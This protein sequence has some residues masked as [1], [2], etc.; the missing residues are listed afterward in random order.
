QRALRPSAHRRPR[1]RGRFRRGQPLP[2]PRRG[3][4]PPGRD[5]LGSP[6]R[7][8]RRGRVRA[9]GRRRVRHAPARRRRRVDRVG[10]GPAAA[11][12]DAGGG[13]EG[14]S[15][16][17]QP[18]GGDVPAA[19][20][21][22]RRDAACR[23][24]HAARRQGQWPQRG[25]PRSHRPGGEYGSPPM[26]LPLSLLLALSLAAARAGAEEPGRPFLFTTVAPT[27]ERGWVAHY[28]AGYSER[29]DAT[30]SEN[31]FEQ[32][33]GVQGRLGHG[34]TLLGRVGLVLDE[35]RNTG[36]TGEAEL[37]KDVASWHGVRTAAGGGV[38]R[39]AAGVTV[40]LARVAVGK[41][42]PRSALWSNLRLE[43]PLARGR[44][45][46]DLITSIGWTRRL[47]RSLHAG[48]EALGEDLEG[49]WEA[50]EA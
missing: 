22:P 50:E 43:R 27:E 11:R 2:R 39:E 35:G 48:V 12:P 37:L 44:D 4:S 47:G 18:G 40:L 6:L 26:K 32:R 36:G 10:A 16:H 7:P 9:P 15:R 23:R 29:A 21:E 42:F 13:G 41:T 3:R 24:P 19:A 17:G 33:V 34:L 38:R 1:R 8:P 49:F 31:G 14:G 20:L 45:A 46:V 30:V 5:G 25:P 28:D